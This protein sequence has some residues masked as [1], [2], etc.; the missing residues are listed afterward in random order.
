MKK[1]YHPYHIITPSP[2][3]F[4]LSINVLLMIMGLLLMLHYHSF[5]LLFIGLTFVL[6]SFSFWI[7]DIIREST[8]QGA[9]TKAAVKGLRIGFILFLASEVML[10]VSFFWAFFHSSLSPAVGIGCM[11]PPMGLTP[12]NVYSIPLLNT[13][14]LLSS[15]VTVTW[16][17]HALISGNKQEACR[18]LIITIILGLIF[19]GFQIFEY[20]E[21]AFSI[22]ESVYGSTFYITTGFHGL[23]VIVGTLFLTVCFFRLYQFHF[24]L[25][26]HFAFEAASWYWH[27]VDVIWLFLYIFIYW[28]GS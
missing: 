12:L 2:W 24:T 1:N 4:V 11:W 13:A 8:F 3:P 14:I 22:A 25:T 10:F 23:H 16:C 21:A 20:F 28:W 9:H 18:S 6:F 27:F 26:N 19:T 7:R 15:G 5:I 17:H